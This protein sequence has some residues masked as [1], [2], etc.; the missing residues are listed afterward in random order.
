MADHVYKLSEVPKG[1]RWQYFLDYYKIPT[2][3]GLA[4][5]IA[6][7]SILKSTVFA[8]KNDLC[9][10]LASKAYVDHEVTRQIMDDMSRMPIDYDGD[11]EVLVS[12]DFVH[13]DPEA[14]QQ[15]PEYFQAQQMKLMAI[16]STAQSALQIV[17]EEAY[18]YLLEEELIGAYGEL[19]E[20]HGHEA[21]D[22]IKIPLTS[23]APF[24]SYAEELPDGLFMTLR[25]KDAMQIHESEKKQEK[26]NYQIKVLETMM[27]E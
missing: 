11:G 14:Q 19:S 13:L 17:D 23:L 20:T 24:R 1:Q 10:L 2:I 4:L 9:I 25:P 5:L 27:E 12:L 26:Y 3:V 22:M 18:Q 8:P 6:I 21:S 16:L 15:D 7:I